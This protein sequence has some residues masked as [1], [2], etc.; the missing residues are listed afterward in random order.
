[1]ASIYDYELLFNGW[2]IESM[3][4]KGGFGEVYIISRKQ[5]GIVQ[6]SAVK[7][8]PISDEQ[9]QIDN[10]LLERIRMEILAMLKMKGCGHVVNIEEF[11]LV[12]WRK[13][14]GQD[15][16]I[17]MELLDCLS[18]IMNKEI[19]PYAEVVKLGIHICRALELCDKYTIIHRDVR[20]PNIFRSPNGDYKLGDFGIARMT[21]KGYSPSYASSDKYMSPEMLKENGC[22]DKRTDIYSLGLT[23][24]VLLN[25]NRFPFRS[26]DMNSISFIHRVLALEAMPS[27]K[28]IPKE[29]AQI[30][31]KACAYDPN[32][33]Y[34]NAKSLR[35][36][37][38]RLQ[39]NVTNESS[40]IT[41]KAKP[42]LEFSDFFM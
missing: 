21:T 26:L 28:N 24:Y 34:M 9:I 20:P 38:E 30:V 13:G 37:L 36:D 1:M 41:K 7:R 22:Y 3:L 23:L 18:D 33:R 12:Q 32:S 35:T 4:G 39:K 27:L 5:L 25:G 16:L 15:V 17:R 10:K 6:Y 11:A 29:L 2:K 19:L 31:K 42:T 14:G 40:K 8:I